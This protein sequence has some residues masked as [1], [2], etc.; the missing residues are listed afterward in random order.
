MRECG[1]G[2]RFIVNLKLW[3]R[4]DSVSKSSSMRQSHCLP[5]AV[6]ILDIYLWWH[7][8]W[9]FNQNFVEP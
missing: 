4:S 7:E 3:L 8:L 2:I 9:R 1:G 5:I 6:F